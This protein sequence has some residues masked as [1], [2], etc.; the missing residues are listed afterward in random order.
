[1][2]GKGMTGDEMVCGI[3][4]SMVMSLSKLHELV[5]DREAWYAAV[6][7]VTE[8]DMTE[9]LNWLTEGEGRSF[10]YMISQVVLRSNILIP[11][12]DFHS[13]LLDFPA[14]SG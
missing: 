2:K 14:N 8:L 10:Q 11:T 6:R 9:W 7:G 12:A 1:M 4:D 13:F 3:T 5:M